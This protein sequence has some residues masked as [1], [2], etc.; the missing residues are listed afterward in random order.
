MLGLNRP[1]LNLSTLVWSFC[2][3]KAYTRDLY[4]VKP[5]NRVQFLVVHM[6]FRGLQ[7]HCKYKNVLSPKLLLLVYKVW[8][9]QG[10][11]L[12]PMPCLVYEVITGSTMGPC[13]YERMQIIPKIINKTRL[14]SAAAAIGDIRNDND[15]NCTYEGENS[16]LL[17][18]TSNWLLSVW[19]RRQ[20][21]TSADTPLGSLE[22]L[23]NVDQLLAEKCKWNSITDIIEPRSKYLFS[24][25]I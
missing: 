6:Y 9:P 10:T 16:L 5:L 2:T 8:V 7:T 21:I 17:Q 18:Q 25:S 23:N 3:L 19:P 13:M 24:N 20:Q 4:G 11:I 15:A 1:G 14:F 12:S 22:F